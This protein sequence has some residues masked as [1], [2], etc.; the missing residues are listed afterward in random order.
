M[1]QELLSKPLQ[2]RSR[3]RLDRK[4]SAEQVYTLD[5][6]LKLDHMIEGSC[7]TPGPRMPGDQKKEKGEAGNNERHPMPDGEPGCWCALGGYAPGRESS[8]R[9]R[10]G[11]LHWSGSLPPQK[12]PNWLSARDHA[13]KLM[14]HQQHRSRAGVGR[15]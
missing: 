4:P 2:T 5:L 7:P 12:S 3:S 1:A 10:I 9:V 6:I 8:L 11:W 15:M 13:F 14:R